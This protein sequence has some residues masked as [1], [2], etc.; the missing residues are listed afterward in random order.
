MTSMLDKLLAADIP[1][2]TDFPDNAAAPGL[3]PFDD[4]VRCNI[5]RDFYDAPVTLSCGHGFC[6]A[7]RE[8]VCLC[9]HTSIMNA[10]GT[11]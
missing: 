1:D 10:P 4:A 11:S 6:S 9:P 8:C 3:R 5:C 7:V 2:P